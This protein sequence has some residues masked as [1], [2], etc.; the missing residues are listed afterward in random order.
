MLPRIFQF[1]ECSLQERLLKYK[2]KRV[3][4][5]LFDSNRQLFFYETKQPNLPF[6]C[7][8]CRGRNQ[9]RSYCYH[10]ITCRR[11][12]VKISLYDVHDNRND[13]DEI[14]ASIEQA[15]VKDDV[16]RRDSSRTDIEVY[17]YFPMHITRP[18]LPCRGE[19]RLMNRT[20]GRIIVAKDQST[21]VIGHS[22]L[23]F[24]DAELL[25]ASA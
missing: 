3:P 4:W 15:D 23:L 17:T 11:E 10:E 14:D 2:N 20:Y 6:Q 21:S 5:V 12:A 7:F 25:R 22:P 16:G 13:D 1:A 24:K 9:K 19:Q 18:V 8:L